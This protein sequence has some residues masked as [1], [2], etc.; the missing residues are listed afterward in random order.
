MKRK[1]FLL[2]YF[3]VLCCAQTNVPAAVKIE[4]VFVSDYFW[5]GF[6]I[7]NEKPA[8]QPSLTLKEERTGI[9]FCIW[10]STGLNRQRT[11]KVDEW[12]FIL[13]YSRVVSNKVEISSGYIHYNFPNGNLPNVTHEFNLGF[14][15]NTLFSPALKVYYDVKMG[16]GVYVIGSV[17]QKIIN[18]PLFAGAAI[19]YNRKM[20]IKYSGISDVT[21]SLSGNV[22]LKYRNIYFLPS[23]NYTIIPKNMQ[24]KNGLSEQNEFWSAIGFGISF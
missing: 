21:F 24:G 1:N 14:S 2:A 11:K 9:C 4:N 22:P 8:F 17:S 7:T 23:I 15:V 20:F 5:R 13:S 10:N 12:D 18:L 19:G 6:D 16:T 3:I